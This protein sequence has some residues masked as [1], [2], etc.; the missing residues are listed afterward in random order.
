MKGNRDESIFLQ[1]GPSGYGLS[2]EPVRFC[3]G[4]RLEFSGLLQ[5][6]DSGSGRC[7]RQRTRTEIRLWFDPAHR[8]LK[9]TAH[10]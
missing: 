3:R 8:E 6:E 9:A 2:T 7:A 5:Q 4:S 1:S 10:P